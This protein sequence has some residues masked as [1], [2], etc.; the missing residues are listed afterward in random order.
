MDI[1]E[2]WS[3]FFFFLIFISVLVEVVQTFQMITDGNTLNQ[4]LSTLAY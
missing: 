2:H 3:D 1:V 4:E